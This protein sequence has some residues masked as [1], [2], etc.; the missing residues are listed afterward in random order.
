MGLVERDEVELVLLGFRRG[1][2]RFEVKIGD[3]ALTSEF[4]E[5]GIDKV[6][7]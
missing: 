6:F 4:L 3:W 1:L 7:G 5:K 2:D